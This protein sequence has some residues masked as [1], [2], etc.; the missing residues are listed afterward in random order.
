LAQACL[1]ARSGA[2]TAAAMATLL[3]TLRDACTIS[4]KKGRDMEALEALDQQSPRSPDWKS[5]RWFSRDLSF[6]SSDAEQLESEARLECHLRGADP[7]DQDTFGAGLSSLVRDSHWLV[8]GTDNC[9]IRC[10]RLA[11]SLLLVSFTLGLQVWLLVEM[12]CFVSASAVHHIRASYDHYELWMYGEE[13]GHTVLVAEGQHRGVPGFFRPERFAALGEELKHD[14]CRIPLSQP[15]FLLPVLLTWALCVV[16]DLRRTVELAHRFLIVTPTCSS[17]VRALGFARA[18]G[19]NSDE[20]VVRSLTRPV[21]AL[22]CVT[23][24]GPRMVLC[25][26]LLWLGSR[27][28]TATQSFGNLMVNAVALQF[29]LGLK[30]L[31]YTTVPARH[32][33]E[34]S[35]TMMLPEAKYERPSCWGYFN[36]FVYFAITISWTVFYTFGFQQVLPHY[37]WDVHHQCAGYIAEML[38]V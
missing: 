11:A 21:K 36:A 25:S 17:M 15:K 1:P 30:D 34:T 35:A 26:V 19:E 28:L 20:V 2:A 7:I 24:F 12:K 33:R 13:P 4:P 16:A 38:K 14:I 37:R 5:S 29:I 8:I 9:L 27:W 18:E 23:I 22:L 32:Q 6:D 31:L 3:R 10:S